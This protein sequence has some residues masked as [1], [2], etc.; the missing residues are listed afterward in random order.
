MSEQLPVR[1]LTSAD[2]YKLGITY[3]RQTL[4]RLEKAGQFPRRVKLT[5]NGSV[6]WVESE[7]HAWLRE[8]INKSRSN[9]ST[10]PASAA[11]QH[12]GA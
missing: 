11:Q 6:R 10:P 1:L 2:L 12:R 8:R 3:A 7:I 9:G 5:P 4:P